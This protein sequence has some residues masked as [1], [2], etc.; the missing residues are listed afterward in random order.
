MFELI[1]RMGIHK[2]NSHATEYNIAK[3]KF[4]ALQESPED[5]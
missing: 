3:A 2:S 1:D 4:I 5:G